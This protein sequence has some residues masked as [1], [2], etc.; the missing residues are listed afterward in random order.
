MREDGALEDDAVR[1][2]LRDKPGQVDSGVD[3]DGSKGGCGGNGL[4]QG[5]PGQGAEL[6]R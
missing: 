5:V 3:T 4:V 2:T 1:E 6:S